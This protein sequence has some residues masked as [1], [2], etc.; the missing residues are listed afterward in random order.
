MGDVLGVRALNRALLER[1]L[2]LRRRKLSAVEALEHLVGLQA[3][4]PHTPYFALWSRLNA[5]RPRELADLITDRRA[6]R[7]TLMRGTIHLVT[8]RDFLAL[9]PVVQPVLDRGLKG[10]FGGRLAGVNTRALAAAGRA[11]LEKQPRTGAA[12]GRLLQHRWPDRDARTLAYAVQYA[13]ALVQ[14]P[15]RAVWGASGQAT[16]ATAE[17]WL[18]RRP[19]GNP[20]P[21]K[22]V[23]RYLAAFGPATV[24]DIQAWSGLT[25]LRDV[26]ER[27]RPRLRTFRNEQGHELF[28]LPHAPRPDP[29]SP[30]PPRFL[31]DFDNALL[32][33]ADRSRIIAGD[34]RTRAGIGKPT[35]L[36]DGF[37]RG[38]WKIARKRAHATLII[39]PFERLRRQDRAAVAEEGARLLTFAAAD[40]RTRD[41][42]FA[43]SG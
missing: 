38:T 22:M 33:H 37:V 2:L 30:A 24:R 39:E 5:F 35:V 20:S 4:T 42:R 12:L 34:H 10:T 6:V 11:L 3:Q 36:V 21:D 8:A 19:A 1:Q 41:V 28:D 13:A 25:R 17:A 14:I 18:G 9:R 27:L 43:R 23:M 26:T 32:A 40:I 7:I 15:P 16:W 29:D 31:P